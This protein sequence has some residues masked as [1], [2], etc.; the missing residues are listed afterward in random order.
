VNNHEYEIR[1]HIDTFTCPWRYYSNDKKLQRKQINNT[2]VIY[3]A[4]DMDSHWIFCL[5]PPFPGLPDEI[6]EFWKPP[7]FLDHGGNPYPVHYH[8]LS[9]GQYCEIEPKGEQIDSR[10]RYS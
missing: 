1:C 3:V 8:F 9:I 6:F 4:H 2:V 5:F 10:N 7:F